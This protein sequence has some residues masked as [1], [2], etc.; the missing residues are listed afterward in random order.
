MKR[1]L[2][3]IFAAAMLFS[4]G[5]GKNKDNSPANSGKTQTADGTNYDN[6]VTFVDGKLDGTDFNWQYFSAKVESGRG[7]E[8]GV[9]ITEN[10]TART[11]GIRYDGKSFTVTDGEVVFFFDHLVSFEAAGRSFS[12]LTDDEGMTAEKFFGSA[13]PSSLKVGDSNSNGFVVFVKEK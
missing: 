8:I 3:A 13:S 5:C 11:V 2:C 9:V 12:V 10:G 1:I 6:T 7:G 4:V